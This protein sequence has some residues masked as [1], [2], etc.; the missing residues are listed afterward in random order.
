M[1]GNE[2]GTW[3]PGIGGDDLS[4][5]VFGDFKDFLKTTP[6]VEKASEHILKKY[7]RTL[8]ES[9]EGPLIWLALAYMQWSY[10]TVQATVMS[11]VREIVT[12]GIGLER[13]REA[14]PAALAKR[15][16]ALKK[17]LK[18]IAEPNNHPKPFPR[19]IVRKPIYQTGDCLAVKLK[20]GQYGAAYVLATDHSHPEYGMNLIVDLD[21]MSEKPPT[22]A[23]F[24]KRNWLIE[25]PPR[26]GPHM[27]YYGAWRYRKQRHRFTT[28]G[29]LP[30]L[31]AD[32]Q[33]KF[34]SYA[35]WIFLGTAIFWIRE[36][37]AA[38]NRDGT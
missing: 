9:D 33:P 37:V 1:G 32:P 7:A 16:T 18:H 24:K 26:G 28:V 35:G 23:A 25:P 34:K 19:L 6:D 20:K 21:Y 10:G 11:R 17:F 13:W 30:P 2:I 29:N 4:K 31:T 12:S 15:T 3:S 22:M 14:G 36:K 38:R 8:K 5:D 27:S